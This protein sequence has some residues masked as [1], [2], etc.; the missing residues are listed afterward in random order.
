MMST[1]S[2]FWLATP[3]FPESLIEEEA[4]YAAGGTF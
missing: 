3:G 1:T 4:D 2:D